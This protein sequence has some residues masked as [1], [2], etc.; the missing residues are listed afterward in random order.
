[1]IAAFG[2]VNA[3]GRS[4]ANLNYK[5]IIFSLWSKNITNEKYPVRGYSF[6]LY[7]TYTIKSY[8]SF[9]NPRTIGITLSFNIE[10]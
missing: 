10:D 9:G 7:P 6:V 1:M 8:K 5:N 2:G 3:A 4:S